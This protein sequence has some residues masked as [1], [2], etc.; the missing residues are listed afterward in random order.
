[1][2]LLVDAMLPASAESEAPP[3]VE[4]VRWTEGEAGDG[5]LLRV[6][7]QIG[8][9]CVVY[10]D[11]RSAYQPGL[12]ELALTLGVGIVVVD[13]DDPVEAKDR[14]FQNLDHVQKALITGEVVLVLANQARLL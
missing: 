6:A 14:L 2:K 1:M 13:A 11:R 8:A 7:A 4:V 10:F 5:E 9:R 3:G 12:R